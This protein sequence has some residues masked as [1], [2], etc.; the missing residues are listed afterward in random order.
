MKASV[1]IIL[2]LLCSSAFAKPPAI[3]EKLPPGAESY[4]ILPWVITDTGAA[5]KA[6][7]I[8]RDGHHYIVGVDLTHTIGYITLAGDRTFKTPE[9]VAL[10]SPLTVVTAAT[11]HAPVKVSRWAF[12]Y[13]PLPSGWNAAFVG[14]PKRPK[15][16]GL[17]PAEVNFLFKSRTAKR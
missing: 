11:K 9:G 5:L 1:I 15:L 14:S 10:G 6:F 16:A 7:R 17:P 8:A 3:G 13:F 4:T 12:Y 2:A